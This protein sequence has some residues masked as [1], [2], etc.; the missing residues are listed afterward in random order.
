MSSTAAR[1]TGGALVGVLV[2]ALTAGAI[3]WARN[4]ESEVRE[5][6]QGVRHELSELHRTIGNKL[7]SVIEFR[8]AATTMLQEHE[9]RLRVIESRASVR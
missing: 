9:R 4:M 8:G 5:G 7:D 6:F 1:T 3:A 2:A